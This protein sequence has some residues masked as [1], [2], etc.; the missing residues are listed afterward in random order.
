MFTGDSWQHDVQ[1]EQLEYGLIVAEMQPTGGVLIVRPP[2]KYLWLR[3]NFEVIYACMITLPFVFEETRYKDCASMCI[4]SSA[5]VLFESSLCVVVTG[6]DTCL[7][8]S[9]TVA[10]SGAI[11]W[12][13]YSL[14]VRIAF[15]RAGSDETVHYKSNETSIF[16][17]L[18]V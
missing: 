18:D 10:D 6:F 9:F 5:A 16:A 14:Y 2:P 8:T 7:I 17:V 11:I 12:L 4:H 13:R 15:Y 1:H 3:R